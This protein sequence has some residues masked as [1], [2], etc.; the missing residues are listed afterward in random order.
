M[1][2][3]FV[4]TQTD[5]NDVALGTVGVLQNAEYFHVH[6]FGLSALKHGVRHAPHAGMDLARAG[7][8]S[9][10]WEFAPATDEAVRQTEAQDRTIAED[11]PTQFS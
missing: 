11:R 7:M 8:V 10:A 6:G 3:A 1:Y 4:A 2:S 5:Q 9:R